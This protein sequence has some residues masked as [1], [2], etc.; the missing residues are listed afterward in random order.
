MKQLVTLSL[1]LSAFLFSSFTF[2]EEGKKHSKGEEIHVLIEP[3]LG[4]QSLSRSYPYDHHL[5]MLT[6]GGRL[7][8][9][10]YDL[11][12]E[13]EFQYGSATES[14]TNPDLSIE[15]SLMQAKLGARTLYHLVD[16]VHLI[17]RAGEQGI[18]FSNTIRSSGATIENSPAW[19]YRPYVG[20]GVIF[21]LLHSIS[22]SIEETY[23]FDTAW[24]TSFGFR[25]Y[26]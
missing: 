25:L 23:V 2:A 24:Q 5:G 3:V 20:T 16:G 19:I 10:T 13:F 11:A 26:F 6:Y 9:G 4:Y 18:H 1:I 17:F 7:V 14:F 22:L 15:T 21:F 12:G 8:V